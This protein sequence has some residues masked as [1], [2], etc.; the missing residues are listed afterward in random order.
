MVNLIGQIV[1]IEWG[2]KNP[3][4]AIFCKVWHL[5][6]K[7]PYEALRDRLYIEQSDVSLIHL[8]LHSGQDYVV[9]SLEAQDR[10][11][12][13]AIQKSMMNSHINRILLY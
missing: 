13:M 12:S 11:P 8:T 2:M 10:V 6:R 1:G 9:P 4:S 7:T 3:T 5:Q